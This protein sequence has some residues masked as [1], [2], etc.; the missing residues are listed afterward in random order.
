MGIDL[1]KMQAKREALE[2]RGGSKTV[3][4][5]PEDGEQTW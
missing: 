5:R 1:S 2:N 4:W 3:F